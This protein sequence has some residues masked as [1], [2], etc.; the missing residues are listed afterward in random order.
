MVWSTI[1]AIAKLEGESQ[2]RVDWV[3]GERGEGELRGADITS[4]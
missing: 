4:D 1:N 3:E 2:K